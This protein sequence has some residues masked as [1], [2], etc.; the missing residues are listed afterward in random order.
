MNFI[1]FILIGIA[2]GFVAWQ[3]TKGC[4][5]GLWVDLLVGIVGGVLGGLVFGLLGFST[6]ILIGSL[7]TAI[8]GAVLLL[9]ITS[10]LFGMEMKE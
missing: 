3:I 9:W 4:G 7:F 10:A 1:W 5:F 6:D 8:I 2:A